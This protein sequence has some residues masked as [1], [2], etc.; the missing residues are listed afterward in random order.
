MVVQVRLDP[1]VGHETAKSRP[2]VVIQNDVGNAASPTTI[3]A[4]I[5][6]AEHIRKLYPF[7]VFVPAGE[8]GLSKDSVIKCDQLRTVDEARLGQVYGHLGPA[9]MERVDDALRVSLAL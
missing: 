2:C 7:H 8:G 3:V 6:G 5:T 1:V 9:T 4:A